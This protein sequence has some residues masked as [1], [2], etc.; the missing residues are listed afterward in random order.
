M[1]GVRAVFYNTKG[2][3]DTDKEGVEATNTMEKHMNKIQNAYNLMETQIKQRIAD[4]LTTQEK[5]DALHPELDMQID[6]Y[7]RFQEYKSL[8]VADGTLSLDEGMTIYQSLGETPE[9]FN[10]QPIHV[11]SVLTSIFQELLTKQ[12]NIV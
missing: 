11:K 2:K 3:I 10:N 5:V 9:H 6:E 8:A 7:V 4:G 12:L 1:A